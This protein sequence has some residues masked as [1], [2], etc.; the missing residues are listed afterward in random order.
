MFDKKDNLRIINPDSIILLL[1]VTLGLLIFNSSFNKSHE[2]KKNSISTQVSIARNSA[3][4]YPSIRLQ[5]FQKTRVSSSNVFKLLSYSKM[6][7]IEDKETDQKIAHLQNVRD[8]SDN[9]S[10]CLC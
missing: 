6:T 2:S 10:F 1:I 8:K 3:D 4:V 5:V 7:F 9:T